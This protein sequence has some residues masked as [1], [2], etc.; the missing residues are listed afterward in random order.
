MAVSRLV[1]QSWGRQVRA[2]MERAMLA[3]VLLSG[4]VDDI[5]KAGTSIRLGLRYNITRGE[6]EWKEKM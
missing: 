1:M 4:Y 5:R 6:W 2:I 3:L